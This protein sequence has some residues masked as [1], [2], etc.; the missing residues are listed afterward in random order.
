MSHNLEQST[1]TRVRRSC[2]TC[3]RG[4]LRVVSLMR[5]RKERGR[6][7]RRERGRERRR[8]RR[9]RQKRA[10]REERERAYRER[11][12]II[13]REREQKAD[14]RGQKAENSEQRVE[15]N[16]QLLDAFIWILLVRLLPRKNWSA[17]VST[18]AK[19]EVKS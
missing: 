13:E 10:Q 3:L 1:H 16:E 19:H 15:S 6:E 11:A 17:V 9:E 8:E 7:R 14:G 2:G 5:E 12:H 18:V 4:A